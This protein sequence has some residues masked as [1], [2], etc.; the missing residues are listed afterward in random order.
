MNANERQYLETRLANEIEDGA[1]CLEHVRRVL[2]DAADEVAR[3]A[4]T[5]AE[6][7]A[8]GDGFT[9]PENVLSW[10]VNHTVSNVLSN[11]RLDLLV[12]AAARIARARAAAE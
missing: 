7:A 9:K 2:A 5:Y 3:Y 6:S 12:T 11:C 4:T 1:R 10:V 8:N